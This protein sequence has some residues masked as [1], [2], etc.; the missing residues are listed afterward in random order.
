MTDP[1]QIPW[2]DQHLARAAELMGLDPDML[3]IDVAARKEAGRRMAE[4]RTKEPR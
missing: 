2:N 4:Q 3:R 1:D